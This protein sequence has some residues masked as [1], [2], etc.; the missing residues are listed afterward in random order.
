VFEVP[1]D[2]IPEKKI[3]DYSF[4]QFPT[5]NL[6]K[7]IHDECGVEITVIGAQPATKL[8]EV[9]PGLSKPMRAAVCRAADRVMELLR[10]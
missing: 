6:L 1:V 4:H 8:A 10:V 9:K 3:I 2:E 5:T 7:E